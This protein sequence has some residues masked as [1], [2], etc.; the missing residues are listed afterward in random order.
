MPKGAVMDIRVV[1][2][3][4]RLQDKALAE[5]LIAA[6]LI[7]PRDIKGATDKQLKAISGIGDVTVQLIRDRIG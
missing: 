2:L 1:K 7:T 3:N 5:R 6:G 4:K